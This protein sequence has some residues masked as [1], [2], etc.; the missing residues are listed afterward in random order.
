MPT[1]HRYRLLRDA[2]RGQEG[3][4]QRQTC[5]G[6][7]KDEEQRVVTAGYSELPEREHDG[8]YGLGMHPETG[9]VDGGT[10]EQCL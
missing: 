2:G 6:R 10:S 5:R 4:D 9:I 1:M 3:S 8:R 7:A